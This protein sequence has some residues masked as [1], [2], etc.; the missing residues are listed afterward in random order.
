MSDLSYQQKIVLER[1]NAG[2]ERIISLNDGIRG[3]AN[4][5]TTASTAVVGLIT[6]AKFLPAGKPGAGTEY[7]LLALVCLFSV[8]IYWLAA[9]VWKGGA[10]TISGTTNVDLLYESYIGKNLDVA[11]CNFLT[12]LCKSMDENRAENGLQATRLDRMV[13]AFIVQLAFL[14][15][16]IA[17]TSIAGYL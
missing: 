4:F 1:L 5:I 6:A 17:W 3:K 7:I 9:L 12:D 16:S 11:Y 15:L 2:N 10:T 8:F 13:V 14:A